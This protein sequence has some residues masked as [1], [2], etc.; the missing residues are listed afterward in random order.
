MKKF[1]WMITILL[2]TS[3][4][5]AACGKSEEKPATSPSPGSTETTAP[6]PKPATVKLGIFKNVTH[7]AGYVALEKGY[8]QE[9]FGDDVKIEVLPFDNGSEFS[10]ALATGEIDLGFVGPGPSTNQYLKSKNFKV[11]SGSN[12]GGAVLA[13]RNDA[14]INSVKDLVGKT[15]AIPTKGSTNEISLR[16]LLEQE[17]L[18]VTTDKSGVQILAAAPADTLTA[19]RQKEIDATLIPEPWGTQIE[20]QGVG[21]I[22]LDWDKIPPNNGNY[23]LVIL[24]A[25]DAFIKDHRDIVKGAIKA[26]LDAIDFIQKN[27]DESYTLIDNRLKELSGKGMDLDLIKAAISRLSL[28]SDVSKEAIEEMAKVSIDAGYIKGIEKD[29]LDLTDFLDLS[30]LDEVKQGK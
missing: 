18:K 25:S 27:P 16:L 9:A 19:F 26:N 8:F 13:V 30:L 29:K 1:T 21:K 11:V 4:V 3:L 7:A 10:T 12:N 22:L 14:G 2:L 23:P 5:L 6:K 15:V 24:V 28:T 20:N 17:G